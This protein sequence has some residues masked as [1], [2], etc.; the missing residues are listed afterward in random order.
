ML[1]SMQDIS[2]T[3]DYRAILDAAALSLA[4]GDRIGS[5]RR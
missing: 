5:G 3:Y 1:F 4:R 2:K